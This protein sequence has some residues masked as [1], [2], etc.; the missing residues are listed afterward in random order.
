MDSQTPGFQ[1]P[2]FLFLFGLSL[3][4]MLLLTA[5]LAKHKRGLW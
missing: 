1:D 5:A 4:V 3:L 2:S